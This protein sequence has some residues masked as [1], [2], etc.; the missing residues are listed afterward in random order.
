MARENYVQELS[1]DAISSDRLRLYT[2]TLRISW[3][4]VQHEQ[5]QGTKLPGS[6]SSLC[7]VQAV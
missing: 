6:D 2:Q 5:G 1:F 3:E 4:T 7:H